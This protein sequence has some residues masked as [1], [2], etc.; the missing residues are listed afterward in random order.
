MYNGSSN[1]KVV[2][3]KCIIY[4][5]SNSKSNDNSNYD[6]NDENHTDNSSTNNSNT[7]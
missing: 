1:N 5:Y 2:I 4:I 7:Y 3:I 6:Q